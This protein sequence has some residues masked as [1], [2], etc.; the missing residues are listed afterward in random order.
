MTWKNRND[1]AQTL[2]PAKGRYLFLN[3]KVWEEPVGIMQADEDEEEEEEEWLEAEREGE[4]EG[5]PNR[6]C[7]CFGR[8]K[9]RHLTLT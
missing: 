3:R 7:D 4:P 8:H 9:Y 1:R 5:L 6:G 2:E